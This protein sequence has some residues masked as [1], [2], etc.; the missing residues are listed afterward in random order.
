MRLTVRRALHRL[1]ILGLPSS[2]LRQAQL[3]SNSTRLTRLELEAPAERLREEMTCIETEP[4]TLAH[5]LCRRK[6]LK[7]PRAHILAQ[8]RTIIIDE[9]RDVLAKIFGVDPYIAPL[10]AHSVDRVLREVHDN[11]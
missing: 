2:D 9:D 10:L 5:G 8:A 3:G 11:L 7:K 4:R 6:R 1:L